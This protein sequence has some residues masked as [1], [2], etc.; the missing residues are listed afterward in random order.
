[1]SRKPE[2]LP[3]MEE[4]ASVAAANPS[5]QSRVREGQPRAVERDAAGPGVEAEELDLDV[6]INLFPE[7][8]GLRDE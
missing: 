5:A 2:R 3:E 6:L 1:M 8:E 4:L 7:E